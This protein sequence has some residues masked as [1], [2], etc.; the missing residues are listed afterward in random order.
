ML[1]G[2]ATAFS[3]GA[4]EAGVATHDLLGRGKGWGAVVGHQLGHQAAGRSLQGTSGSLSPLSLGE[5]GAEREE[6]QQHL[7]LHLNS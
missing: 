5:A 7:H 1:E 2:E 6:Q 4:G 3:V